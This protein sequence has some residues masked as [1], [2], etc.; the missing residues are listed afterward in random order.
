MAIDVGVTIII[1][2]DCFRFTK[3]KRTKIV[4]NLCKLSLSLSRDM[5]K[6]I[7]FVEYIFVPSLIKSLRH[8]FTLR[9]LLKM[10]LPPQNHFQLTIKYLL[11]ALFFLLHVSD[12]IANAQL[13]ACDRDVYIS[14]KL[15]FNSILFDI[16]LDLIQLLTISFF[17]FIGI[18]TPRV[19]YVRQCVLFFVVVAAALYVC[20]L[21]AGSQSIHNYE[22]THTHG[23]LRVLIR[24]TA[25]ERERTF[26]SNENAFAT[27]VW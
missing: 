2:F 5:F 18:L 1:T 20:S 21:L 23:R 22:H 15:V 19:F 9:L 7:D 26:E 8:Y 24:N 10:C 4:I 14:Q 6:C 25:C 16:L 17:H 13:W 3:K 27:F 11:G 12:D